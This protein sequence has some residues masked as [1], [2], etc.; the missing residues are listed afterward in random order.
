VSESCA[1]SS[2][3]GILWSSSSRA[4]IKSQAFEPKVQFILIYRNLFIS[5]IS[6][7]VFL[8]VIRI[9]TEIIGFTMFYNVLQYCY[10]SWFR[11]L[12][13]FLKQ[14]YVILLKWILK[15]IRIRTNFLTNLYR[16]FSLLSKLVKNIDHIL[17]I[18]NV[19]VK[20]KC[21]INLFINE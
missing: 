20:M 19:K 1:W 6:I 9:F 11:S 13:N 16:G 3:L 21:N 4:Q 12:E 15:V 8:K 18:F 2:V 14:W 5:C 7:Y 17:I 10:E